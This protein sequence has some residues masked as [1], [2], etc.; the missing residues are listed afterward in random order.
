MSFDDK[1][2]SNYEGAPTR[3]YEFL[4]GDNAA[5][6]YSAGEQAVT[7]TVDSEDRVF[8]PIPISDTGITESGDSQSDDFTI[9][10]PSTAPFTQLFIGTPPSESIF[11]VVRDSH[12]GADDA[13]VVWS[14]TVR[15]HKRGRDALTHEVICRS[16][17]ASLDRNGLRLSWSR[18]CP[19]ALYDRSCKVNP[20]SYAVTTQVV[21][22]DTNGDIQLSGIGG[23]ANNWFAG[24]YLEF[25][26]AAGVT[27][28]RGIK[29]HASGKIRLLGARDG[30]VVG[31][32]VKIF[33]GCDLV[34]ATCETKF[35]NLNNYGGFP[36]LPNKSPFDGDPVF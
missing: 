6:R 35:N 21:A 5:W 7:I 8:L 9:T 30:V 36:H 22:L 28:R 14:G 26:G 32:W 18:G 17:T 27:E 11:V 31:Q 12:L 29:S 3:L 15:S 4:L 10:M 23:Y 13:P 24:G 20:N 34:T 1:E 25:T 2:I 33:P 16:L 19:H